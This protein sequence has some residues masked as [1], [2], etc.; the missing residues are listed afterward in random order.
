M[1]YLGLPML[2]SCI[3][4]QPNLALYQSYSST[5]VDSLGLVI[6]SSLEI[7]RLASPLINLVVN[8]QTREHDLQLIVRSPIQV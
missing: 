7:L 8:A 6:N 1:L 2:S 3:S 4:R 5:H